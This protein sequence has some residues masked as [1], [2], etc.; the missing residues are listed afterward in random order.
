MKIT[1]AGKVFEVDNEELSKALEDKKESI[2]IE[3]D[4]IIRTKDE[5][6]TFITNLKDAQIKVGKEIGIKEFKKHVGLEVEGKDYGKVAEAFK[7]KVI[8]ESNISID[9]KEKKWKTDLQTLK[10]AN[11]RITGELETEKNSRLGIEKKFKVERHIDKL[12]PDTLRIPKDDMTLILSNKYD[13]DISEDG[14]FVAKDKM[15]GKVLQ[16]DATLSPTPFKEVINGFFEKNPDYLTGV[17][18]GNGGGDSGGSGK[19]TIE[20]YTK[21]LVEAGHAPNSE[22]FNAEMQKAIDAKTVSLED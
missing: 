16:N 21:T 2:S 9:E 20:S 8:T 13:F 7:E 19:T 22:S 11:T 18:G 17:E 15:T 5:N 14:Q 6:D 10:D 3:S 4:H 12:M 1:I